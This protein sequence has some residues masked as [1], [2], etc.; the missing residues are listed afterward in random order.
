M[1]YY[2]LV[3]IIIDVFNI[4]KVIINL[5]VWYHGFHKLII[6]NCKSVFTLKFWSLLYNFLSIK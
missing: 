4:A 3:K 5:V 6:S 1:I 2:K